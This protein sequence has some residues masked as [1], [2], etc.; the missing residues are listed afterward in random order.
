MVF[1]IL[2]AF[3]LFSEHYSKNSFFP[4]VNQVFRLQEETKLL[5]QSSEQKVGQLWT[6]LESMRTSRQELGGE[7]YSPT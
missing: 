1:L 7:I 5:K 4:F 3:H 6:Q 2:E